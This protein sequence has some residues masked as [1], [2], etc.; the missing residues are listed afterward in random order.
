[1]YEDAATGP[2]VEPAPSRVLTLLAH[3][4]L[5][6]AG[7]VI[8]RTGPVRVPVVADGGGHIDSIDVHMHAHRVVVGY[9]NLRR[10]DRKV[11]GLV[12]LAE[13]PVAEVDAVEV[14]VD[15]DLRAGAP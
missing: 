1:H 14:G 4:D 3:A 8:A 6:A 5:Q 2:H 7:V 13:V 10:T 12:G 9:G 11:G 15:G